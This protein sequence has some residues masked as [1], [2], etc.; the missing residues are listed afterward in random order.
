MMLT[1]QLKLNSNFE[2][3][4]I[5]LNEKRIHIMNKKGPL[6]IIA[7]IIGFLATY[8]LTP[9]NQ[10]TDC[11]MQKEISQKIIRFHVR[12]NSDSNDDQN[13][14]LKVKDEVVSYL[15]DAMK[16]AASKEDSI[17]YIKNHIDEI[18]N[19]AQNVV[20]NAGYNY[21]VK[22]Y[23]TNEFF[24]TKSYGD[25]TIPCGDYDAFRIDIGE[26]AGHN[27]WC[28][29]YPPLCFVQGSYGIATDESKQLLKNVLDE[30]EFSYISN[31]SSGEIRFDFKLRTLFQK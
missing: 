20:K 10:D 23:M 5:L 31:A 17:T 28:I 19:V 27:W 2:I 24:P 8:A 12:A 30:D 25:V 26:N 29:L 15:K 22:A 18:T 13:L 1:I 7:I 21:S 9:A 11:N 14:K 6:L 16:K 4:K 3:D